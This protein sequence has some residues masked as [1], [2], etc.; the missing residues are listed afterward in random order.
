MW[1]IQVKH[2]WFS[3][4]DERDTLNFKKL[5]IDKNTWATFDYY[6]TFYYI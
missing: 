2:F 1:E 6:L 4:E 5:Y 3:L